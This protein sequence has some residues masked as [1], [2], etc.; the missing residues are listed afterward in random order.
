MGIRIVRGRKF[1]PREAAPSVIV[2]ETFQRTYFPGEDPLGRRIRFGNGEWAT[3][4]GVAQDVKVR[5]AREATY[6]E[7]YIPYWQMT[8]PGMNVLL[9]MKGGGSPA[10]LIAP[11]RQAVAAIDRN[12]PVS[13]VVMLAELVGD[14]I[15]NPRFFATLAFTFALLAVALA[16]VGIYGVMSYAVSQRTAE[17]GVRMAVGASAPDVFRLVIADGLKVTLVGVAAGIGGSLLVARSLGALLFGVQAR[18]PVT[19]AITACGLVAVAAA[20]CFLPAWRATRVDAA[21]ALRT[22]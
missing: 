13:G 18:D 14:S 1:E 5:G 22:D 11:L 3:I 6:V 21:V 16:A 17:I 20:A 9:K 12:V 7:T 10:Q 15:E 4:V 8:E 2:N 19:L